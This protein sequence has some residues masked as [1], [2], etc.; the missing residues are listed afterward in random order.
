ML[1]SLVALNHKVTRPTSTAPT[2]LT[3][4]TNSSTPHISPSPVMQGT[5]PSARDETGYVFALA[6]LGSKAY[7]GWIKAN[8]VWNKAKETWN[9]ANE[10]LNQAEDK[11]AK[12][13]KVIKEGVKVTEEQRAKI[14]KIAEEVARRKGDV[15]EAAKEAAEAAELVRRKAS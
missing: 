12:A 3:P 11:L 2:I 10:A 7:R 14:E 5:T 13:H 8:E 1:P 15:E 4:I 9:K 6:N